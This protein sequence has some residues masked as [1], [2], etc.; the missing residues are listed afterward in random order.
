MVLSAFYVSG[1]EKSCQRDPGKATSEDKERKEVPGSTLAMEAFGLS[2]RVTW[3]VY[4]NE[5]LVKANV[6]F[7]IGEEASNHEKVWV[8]GERA[9]AAL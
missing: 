9:A 2:S 7:W 5:R 6:K 3:N 1:P 8:R 4:S